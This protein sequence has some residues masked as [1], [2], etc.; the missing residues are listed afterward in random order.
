MRH[1]KGSLAVAV[2]L[3][4][5]LALAAPAA[6]AKARRL[7]PTESSSTS[8]PVPAEEKVVVAGSCSLGAGACSDYEGTFPGVDLPAL[9]AGS[10]GKWS[11][12]PCP[13]EG[14]VATCMQR[15][16]N[17]DDRIVVRTYSPGT[18]DQAK[19]A[20]ANTPRSIFL[21]VK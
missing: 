1:A 9:C 21:T 5:P 3:V 2:L 8:L 4:A 15:Q 6:P 7:A 18:R 16:M 20:C 11:A 17:S 12:S 10:K 19:K 13:V 14:T